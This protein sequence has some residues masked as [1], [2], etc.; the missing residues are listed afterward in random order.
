LG[1]KAELTIDDAMRDT[2]NYLRHEK[3]D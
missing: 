1:W 3:N 2:I